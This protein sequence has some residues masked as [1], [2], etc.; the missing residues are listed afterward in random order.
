M[1][2]LHPD[3]LNQITQSKIDFRSFKDDLTHA[4]SGA[5]PTGRMPFRRVRAVLVRWD[6]DNTKADESVREML[7]VFQDYG[8]ACKTA[9]I[10]AQSTISPDRFLQRLMF[11]MGEMGESGDLTIFYYAGHGLWDER[12]HSLELQ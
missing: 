3:Q 1:S 11:D 10:P 12:Q 9:I 7:Q 4:I 8:Y 5:F 2:L 6:V